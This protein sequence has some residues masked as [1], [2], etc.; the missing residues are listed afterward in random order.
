M[1]TR[2][3]DKQDSIKH[4]EGLSASGIRA[5]GQLGS[6]PGDL[7]PSPMLV[8]TSSGEIIRFNMSAEKLFARRAQELAGRGF[9]EFLA[10]ASR[11]SFED[12]LDELK[13][14]QENPA[15]LEAQLT[16]PDASSQDILIH[17]RC[18]RQGAELLFLM[19]INNISTWRHISP[20]SR[21][22]P[23]GGERLDRMQAIGQLASAIAH[24]F[25]N[26][27]S[28]ITGYNRVLLNE[29]EDPELSSFADK[30]EVASKRAASLVDHILMYARGDTP[31]VARVDLNQQVLKIHDFLA[32]ILG[33]NIEWHFDL[34]S[35]GCWV[36]LSPSQI[37]QVL[38]NL[39]LNA[40]D[41]M[42]SSGDLR[43]TTRHT[44]LG[45][46]R[47]GLLRHLD[48]GPHVLLEVCDS[49]CGMDE[50]SARRA[51]EPFYSSKSSGEGAGLGLATVRSI[52]RS[53][54]GDIF[55]ESD[56]GQ[57]ACFRLLFPTAQG[58]S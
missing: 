24:D 37:D 13:T 45:A 33:R 27:L 55:L 7:I 36:E 8:L 31:A 15:T 34:E 51:F 40:R 57:G 53:S 6:I 1:S 54:G 5:P 50:E 35:A 56:P 30:I 28:V 42:E 16:L 26:L 38:M 32:D 49:G 47:P 3:G 2:K 4:Q 18:W 43:L 52:V 19:S 22:A 14:E 12:F 41:A 58:D 48:Q 23:G 21:V 11:R 25:N 20:H 9:E 44:T 10:D 39:I 46:E 17:G 29:L